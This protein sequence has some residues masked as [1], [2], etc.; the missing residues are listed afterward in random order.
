MTQ[1]PSPFVMVPREVMD[2]KK[3]CIK[4]A[5]TAESAETKSAGGEA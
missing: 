5:V 3:A 1:A 2:Q 4:G